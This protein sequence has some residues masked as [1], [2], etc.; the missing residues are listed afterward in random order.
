V[1]EGFD[2]IIFDSPITL[3]IPDVAVLAPEMDRVLLIH[4][5]GRTGKRQ[6]IAA[7][8]RLKNINANMHGIIF[9]NVGLRDLRNYYAQ[10]QTYNN[11]YSS[12]Q[13]MKFSSIWRRSRRRVEKH[14][15]IFRQIDRG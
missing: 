6:V 5:P 15:P 12:H 10:E 3:S 8:R 2:I 13:N 11:Y 4:S 7:N 1:E 14:K 9:N